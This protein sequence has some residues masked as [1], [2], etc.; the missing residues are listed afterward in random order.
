MYVETGNASEAYRRAY[1]A[2]SMKA[3]TIKVKAS[4][5]LD[6]DNIRITI[7]QLQAALQKRMDI[8]K[9]EV[10]KELSAIVRV[11]IT[12]ILS[13]KGMSVRVKNLADLPDEVR[14]CIKSIKKTKGGISIEL[15]DKISASDRLSRMLGWDEATTV[16]VQGSVPIQEWLKKFGNQDKE[17]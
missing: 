7:Q 13:A 8:S 12:D 17:E 1:N 15:Y 3:E 11:R 6:K 10:V 4:Q 16:K 14:S 2:D 9:D 5:M